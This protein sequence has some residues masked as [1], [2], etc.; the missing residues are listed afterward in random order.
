MLTLSV[1]SATKSD[2]MQ[3]LAH[4]ADNAKRTIE[5]SIASSVRLCV[6]APTVNVHVSDKVMKFKSSVPEKSLKSFLTTD[7]L[8]KYSYLFKQDHEDSS[9]IEKESLQVWIQRMLST[10]QKSIE[11][12]VNA[13]MDGSN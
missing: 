11:D 2:L 7:V 8:A 6:V 12:H 5:R 10:M 13:A 3:R 4:E 1:D 9:P